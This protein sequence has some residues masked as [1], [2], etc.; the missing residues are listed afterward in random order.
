MF[1]AAVLSIVLTLVAGPDASLLCAIWCH[2]E[3]ATAGPCEHPDPMSTPGVTSNDSCPGMAAVTT[4]FVR[5]D[6]RRD[7][8]SSAGQ[9][10]LLIPPFQFVAPPRA[11][12]LGRELRQQRPL[13]ARPLVV[14]LRI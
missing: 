4:A 12:E 10:P 14:S 5:E 3:I 8:S 1:R 9:I 11:S 13:E 7:V 6:V 2:P